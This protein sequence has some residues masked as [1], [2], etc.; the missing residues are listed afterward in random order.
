MCATKMPTTGAAL[1][2]MDTELA[3]LDCVN[4]YGPNIS[5]S[6]CLCA[7]FLSAEVFCDELESP[8]NGLVILINDNTPGSEA[9]Y[10]CDE[11]NGYV[12]TPALLLRRCL[13][14]GEWTGRAPQCIRT[15][16]TFVEQCLPPWLRS[17]MLN[18]SITV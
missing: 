13:A 6:V 5:A 15:Y 17:S 9:L 14:T 12:L 1:A 4:H 8:E 16:L 7:C 3:I 18:L 2:V 11:D 10:S